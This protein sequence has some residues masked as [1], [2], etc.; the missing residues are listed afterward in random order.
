MIFMVRL[1]G[2]TILLAQLKSVC[3]L[4]HGVEMKKRKNQT[5]FNLK[6]RCHSCFAIVTATGS[7]RQTGLCLATGFVMPVTKER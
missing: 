2:K 5:I 3:V 1:A 4:S 6:T 7:V